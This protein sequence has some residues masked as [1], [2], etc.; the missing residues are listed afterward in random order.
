[1]PSLIDDGGEK[2][3]C[4]IALKG[5]Q[6][7]GEVYRLHHL[8]PYTCREDNSQKADNESMHIFIV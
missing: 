2:N 7:L 3:L 4:L 5:L 8:G 1:M 6:L